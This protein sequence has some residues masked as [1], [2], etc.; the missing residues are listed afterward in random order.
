MQRSLGILCSL[1][2]KKDYFRSEC[3][4]YLVV[5]SLVMELCVLDS[6]NSK[7]AVLDQV[8]MLLEGWQR[9]SYLLLGIELF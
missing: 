5:A 6:N 8:G 2:L 4:D 7:G 9:V 3:L 1:N